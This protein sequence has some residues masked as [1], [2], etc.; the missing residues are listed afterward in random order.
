MIK[1]ARL[2]GAT[3]AFGHM[4]WA[5]LRGTYP[6]DEDHGD[7]QEGHRTEM[8]KKVPVTV[9]RTGFGLCV[10]VSDDASSDDLEAIAHK[11]MERAEW[12]GYVSEGL[13]EIE[14]DLRRQ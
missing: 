9:H 14:Q 13:T 1:I 7:G 4:V 5:I 6:E 8:L 10:H 2:V 3:R 12:V 11:L